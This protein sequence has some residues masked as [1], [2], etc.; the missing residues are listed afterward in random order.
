MI[1]LV[2]RFL[3]FLFGTPQTTSAPEPKRLIE[4]PW[5]F[6]ST[7]PKNVE[8]LLG[9]LVR[10]TETVGEHTFYFWGGEKRRHL[11]TAQGTET[12]LARHMVWWM[13]GR[14]QPKTSSGLV[15]NCGEPKC[16]KLSHLILKPSHVVL[17]PENKAQ[18]KPEPKGTTLPKTRIVKKIEVE[19]KDL[20]RSKC[21]S[22]K[23]Y[24]ATR[25]EAQQHKNM[26]N[27]TVMKGKNSKLYD[28]ECQ[29]MDCKG[30]HLTHTN[31]NPKNKKKRR[32]QQGIW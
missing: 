3:S 23:A 18:P 25:L 9:E 13:F 5:P 26:L 1:T 32:R 7:E 27:R 31:P 8:S 17:G 19:K 29:I 21:I 22:N 28:Y 16:I 30:Y 20:Q 11:R 6:P 12:I 15:T 24:F 2:K 10:G 4:Y 14:K